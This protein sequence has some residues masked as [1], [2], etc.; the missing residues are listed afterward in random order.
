MIRFKVLPKSEFVLIAKDI[1]EI[2]VN[3]MSSIAPTG[4]SFDEDFTDW[5]QA[6]S[7]GIQKPTRNII[8]IYAYDILVGFFQFYTNSD[9]LFM[10][11]EIQ[12][13]PKY[14]GK[15]YNIFRL[16]YGFLFSILPTNLITVQAYVDK[17]NQKSQNI[18]CHLGL[19]IIGENK[20]GNSFHYQGNYDDLLKWYHTKK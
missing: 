20:N 18:L 6:V 13:S 14:Q 5:N 10:M 4:N 3:N 12:L 1:F 8:L 11:E 7:E 19:H 15:E 16:L 2:L 9:G 17:R